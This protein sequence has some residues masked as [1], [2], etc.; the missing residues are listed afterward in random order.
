MC[1][2]LYMPALIIINGTSWTE[3]LSRLFVSAACDVMNLEYPKEVL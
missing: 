3:R 2:L 1:N